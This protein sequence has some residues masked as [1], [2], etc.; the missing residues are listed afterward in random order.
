M[1]PSILY[2]RPELDKIYEDLGTAQS[3]LTFLVMHPSYP[4]L[5]PT[6]AGIGIA[7][8]LVIQKKT[9]TMIWNGVHLFLVQVV[10][11]MYLYGMLLPLVNVF[12]I[13]SKDGSR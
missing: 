13:I 6:L 11:H 7:K 5:L 4:W 1:F 3:F 9:V 2:S 10:F 12:R 8:E